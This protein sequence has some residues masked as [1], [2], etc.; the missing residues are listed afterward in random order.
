MLDIIARENPDAPKLCYRHQGYYKGEQCPKCNYL[1]WVEVIEKGKANVPKNVNSTD[2]KPRKISR[3]VSTRRNRHQWTPCVIR[4]LGEI[5]F[6]M[7]VYTSEAR[8][9][10]FYVNQ[11]GCAYLIQ[12]PPTARIDPK[13]LETRCREF[14]RTEVWV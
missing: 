8:L 13:N 1:Q 6:P 12:Q 10:M 2:K 7:F 3:N 14:D 4:E 11:G 5:I 9:K